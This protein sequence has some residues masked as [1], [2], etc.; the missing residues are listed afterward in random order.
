M[1]PHVSATF[2]PMMLKTEN[3]F[4]VF[5]ASR[6]NQRTILSQIVFVWI[7]ADKFTTLAPDCARWIPSLPPPPIGPSGWAVEVNL[8]CYT[9]WFPSKLILVSCKNIFVAKIF[10]KHSNDCSLKMGL[11]INFKIVIFIFVT[12]HWCAELRGASHPALEHLNTV[13]NKKFK[14]AMLIGVLK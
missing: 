11:R 10:P 9:V 1:V 4:N 13:D 7:P 3:K 2:Q 5:A 8:E 12:R 6:F 14:Y